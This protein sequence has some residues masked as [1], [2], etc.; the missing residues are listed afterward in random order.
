M[1]SA[2][3]Y[4]GAGSFLPGVPARDLSAAEAD[5]YGGADAL[6][7][8]GLYARIPTETKQATGPSANKLAAPAAETKEA[9]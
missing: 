6:V 5:A 4:V 1:Q 8:S 3:R 2:L 7:A 9:E